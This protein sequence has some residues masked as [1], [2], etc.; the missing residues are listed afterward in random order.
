ML[1]KSILYCTEIVRGPKV[2]ERLPESM[3]VTVTVCAPTES[4]E[5]E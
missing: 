3:A 1:N 5:A 4:V 2:V